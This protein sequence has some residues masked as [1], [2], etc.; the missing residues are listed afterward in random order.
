MLQQ[1]RTELR[2]AVRG[3][4][5]TYGKLRALDG[6]DLTVGRGLFGLLGPN[7]SGKST[8]MRTL[9]TLQRPDQGSIEFAGIDVLEAPQ[10]LRE[11]L[12]YLPQEF[13]VYPGISARDLLD[14]MAR[15]RGQLDGRARKHRVAA[16]LE[17][18][19]LAAHADREVASFSGGMRQR[20]G[21]AQALLGNPR[22]L[23]VDEPTAGLDPAERSRFH[24]LLSELGDAAVVLLSTHIVEDVASVCEDVAI[25]AQGRIA[26]GGRPA[27]LVE[28]LRGRLWQRR[29]GRREVA[30]LSPR[31]LHVRPRPG[32]VQAVVVAS[33]CP[34][35]GWEAKAPDLEDV[36]HEALH[37][38]G[39]A[40]EA[41]E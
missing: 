17:R 14:Y 8:L 38:V 32:A 13:G 22:L 16:L 24:Q 4:T 15:F 19:N 35:E 9:A 25:I 36:Y 34:G 5:K 1:T 3:L 7:G 28:T 39:A 31:P 40:R 27:E 11:Q 10:Q 29:M 37:R 21:I 20:F 12:G 6:L 41:A 2:L 26:L 18:V 30:E 23:I 33:D